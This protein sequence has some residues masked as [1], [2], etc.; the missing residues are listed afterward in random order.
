M[1]GINIYTR[2]CRILLI[3]L[4]VVWPFY[5][6]WNLDD[7]R[8]LILSIVGF[9]LYVVAFIRYIREFP[10]PVADLVEEERRARKSIMV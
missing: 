8:M 2:N 7:I 9:A 3:I 6:L 1:E 10:K 4:L 5:I